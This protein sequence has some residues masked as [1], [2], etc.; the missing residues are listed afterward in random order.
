MKVRYWEKENGIFSQFNARR[1]NDTQWCS[2]I[3]KALISRSSSY[4]ILHGNST[5][6]RVYFLRETQFQALAI[7]YHTQKT[8][9]G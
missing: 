8:E 9:S 4:H 1:V 2:I 7:S 6:R 3:S 5:E